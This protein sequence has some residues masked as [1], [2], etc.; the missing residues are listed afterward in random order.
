MLQV[1]AYEQL[2]EVCRLLHDPRLS[3]NDVAYAAAKAAVSHVKKSDDEAIPFFV[4][5][6][7]IVPS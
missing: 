3:R 2:A 4:E 1:T 7:R 6:G 5:H